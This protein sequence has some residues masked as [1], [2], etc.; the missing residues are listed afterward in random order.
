MSSKG[1]NFVTSNNSSNS[2]KNSFD[3][4]KLD[5]TTNKSGDDNMENVL[6]FKKVSDVRK[7]ECENYS[8]EEM[9]L[10]PTY[11][12]QVKKYFDDNYKET[13][14]EQAIFESWRSRRTYKKI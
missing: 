12:A 11:R 9:I 13:N 8:I 4:N 2:K 1:E 5:K 7:D 14:E 6:D 10:N 3:K